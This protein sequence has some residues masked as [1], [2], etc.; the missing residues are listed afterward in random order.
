MFRVCVCVIPENPQKYRIYKR[1]CIRNKG[2]LEALKDI[3]QFNLSVVSDSAPSWTTACQVSL[4]INNTQNLHKLMSTELWCHP[5]ISSSVIPFSSRLQS[6]PASGSF[7]M[8]QFL[9]PGGQS[10]GVSASV[11]PM[12]IQGWFNLGS[13][14]PLGWPWEAQSSPR[15]A[16]ESWG[17]RSSHCRA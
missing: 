16:R 13:A 9:T 10:I 2:V 17:W 3:V 15:V 1:F 7:P 8:S 6:F 5:T 11:L 14:F 4:S 12:N